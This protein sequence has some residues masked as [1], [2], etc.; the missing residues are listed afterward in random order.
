MPT[1]RQDRTEGAQPAEVCWRSS[2]IRLQSW[3]GVAAP[4][5]KFASQYRATICGLG[6]GVAT[7]PVSG[8]ARWP[9]NISSRHSRSSPASRHCESGFAC[10]MSTAKPVAHQTSARRPTGV[11]HTR[12]PRI[13]LPGLPSVETTAGG[14]A[15]GRWPPLLPSSRSLEPDHRPCRARDVES[16]QLPASPKTGRWRRIWPPADPVDLVC[17][18]F[19]HQR[20]LVRAPPSLNV[21]YHLPPDWRRWQSRL[22]TH[23]DLHRGAD[24]AC[25]QFAPLPSFRDS[26]VKASCQ[27]KLAKYHHAA[28]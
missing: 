20:D 22:A 21:R 10:A 25:F 18:H 3:A 9:P 27:C 24:P 5:L 23:P 8:P 15:G 6:S 2:S 11:D 28:C 19:R 26:Y 17:V 14:S 1:F 16:P 12:P 7:N 4:R 13:T